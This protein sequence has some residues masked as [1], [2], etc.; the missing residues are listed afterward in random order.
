MTLTFAKSA[1]ISDNRIMGVEYETRQWYWKLVTTDNFYWHFTIY[2][3]LNI[4]DV[5]LCLF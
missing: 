3:S 5:Y 2:T 1:D 4:V